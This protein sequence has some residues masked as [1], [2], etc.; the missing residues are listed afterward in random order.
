[1]KNQ[2]CCHADYFGPAANVSNPRHP[3]L[4]WRHALLGLGTAA[5]RI[6]RYRDLRTRMV[7]DAFETRCR[8][9]AGADEV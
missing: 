7:R 2:N 3:T 5:A 1:M 6:H 8:Q 9:L 4:S